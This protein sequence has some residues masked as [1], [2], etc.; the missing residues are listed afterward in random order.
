M[1][2]YSV[3]KYV[4]RSV[5]K[6][7]KEN[8]VHISKA[9]KHKYLYYKMK[10]WKIEIKLGNYCCLATLTPI[11]RKVAKFVPSF[12]SLFNFWKCYIIT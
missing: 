1:V 3:S 2:S 9:Q 6:L 11:V 5:D 4:C 12:V 10:R 8:R 7:T